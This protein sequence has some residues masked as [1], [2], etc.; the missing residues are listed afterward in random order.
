[1]RLENMEMPPR[2]DRAA[3]KILYVVFFTSECG[4][5][6]ICGVALRINVLEIAIPAPFYRDGLLRQCGFERVRDYLD[7]ASR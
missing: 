4:P 7:L 5:L 6:S 2:R 3:G 1:M